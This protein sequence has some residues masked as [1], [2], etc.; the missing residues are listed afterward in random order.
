MKKLLLFSSLMTILSFASMQKAHAQAT[1]SASI[2]SLTPDGSTSYLLCIHGGT[3]GP[4]TVSGQNAFT[5]STL[6][7]SNA[8]VGM[9]FNWYA[10]L[11]LVGMLGTALLGDTSGSQNL[12]L[13]TFESWSK[14]D[15]VNGDGSTWGTVHTRG[16]VIAGIKSGETWLS[17]AVD[18]RNLDDDEF[19]IEF[20]W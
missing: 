15:T 17:P 8:T 6:N 18:L 3:H 13:A 14:S 16:T 19:D 1:Y 9:Q 5:A 12:S 7:E 11:S 4:Q 2:N 20:D 10:D